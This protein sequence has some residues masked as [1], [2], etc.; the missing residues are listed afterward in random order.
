MTGLMPRRYLRPLLLVL[1]F[2]VAIWYLLDY[3]AVLGAVAG[4]VVV[5]AW[6]RRRRSVRARRQLQ[7]LGNLLTLTPARFEEA[8]ADLLSRSGYRRVRINGGAADLGTDIF[9]EDRRGR[10]VVVQCK[11]HAPGIAVGSGEIQRF[12]GTLAHHRANQGLF[13]T[14]SRF[15]GPAAELAA[16]HRIELMDGDRLAELAHRLNSG[17]SAATGASP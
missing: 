14:T 3:P 11:R 12:L 10:S 6:V 8:V 16:H 17:R 15:T 1:G 4:T 9:C 7:T 2:V 13:V 5:T